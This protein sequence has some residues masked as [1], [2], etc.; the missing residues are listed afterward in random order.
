MADRRD[1]ISNLYR[2]VLGREP[3][4]DGLEYWVGTPSTIEEIRNEFAKSPEAIVVKTFQLIS[5]YKEL[6]KRDADLAGVKYWALVP[7]SI[8]DIRKEFMKSEE[9]KNANPDKVKSKTKKK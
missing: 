1:D 5:M 7:S 3:D 6:F 9:Y 8:D 4:I 2:T